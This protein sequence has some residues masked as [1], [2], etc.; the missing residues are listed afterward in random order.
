MS[1]ELVTYN[2]SASV[3]GYFRLMFSWTANGLIRCD[4]TLVG[5][6]AVS[7]ADAFAEFSVRQG[8]GGHKCWAH[9][10]GSEEFMNIERHGVQSSTKR[11]WI[12]RIAR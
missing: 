12:L 11:A 5:L 8:N 6:P 10:H 2:P 4:A 3:F 7:Y 9:C 1:A